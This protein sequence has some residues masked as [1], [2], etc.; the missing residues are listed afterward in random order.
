MN[1]EDN[2]WYRW[3]VNIARPYPE[4][5]ENADQIA[6]IEPLRASGEVRVSRAYLFNLNQ[7]EAGEEPSLSP[8]FR[9]MFAFVD[10]G[11]AAEFAEKFKGD[12]E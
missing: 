3:V 1:A 7:Y 6:Y 5:T 10:G 11:I 2:K 4:T 9:Y 8:G 12:F